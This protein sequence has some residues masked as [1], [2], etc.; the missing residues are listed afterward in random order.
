MEWQIVREHYPLSHLAKLNRATGKA[1]ANWV[2]CE[3]SVAE[4]REALAEGD[5][6]IGKLVEKC[7]VDEYEHK[8]VFTGDKPFAKLPAIA[9]EELAKEVTKRAISVPEEEEPEAKK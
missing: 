4:V 1:S 7:V 6:A 5:E 8:R 3:P 2:I 9:A